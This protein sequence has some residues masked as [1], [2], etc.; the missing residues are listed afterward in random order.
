MRSHGMIVLSAGTLLLA[1]AAV[2]AT[3]RAA[4]PASGLES[5][6]AALRALLDEQWQYHLKVSP[7]LASYIGDKRYNDQ[8]SDLS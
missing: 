7:E 1:C 3:A 2:A 4:A 5:R 8:L 6:R